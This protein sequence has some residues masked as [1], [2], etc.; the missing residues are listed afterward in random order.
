MQHPPAL[1]FDG[2]RLG[3]PRIPDRESQPTAEDDRELLVVVLVRRDLAA[4]LDPDLVDLRLVARHPATEDLG[5][6]A[7]GRQ[8][9]ESVMVGAFHG[10]PPWVA[11][12]T[13][14][15][16]SHSRPGSSTPSL[17]RVELQAE[18]RPV[19]AIVELE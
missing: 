3:V 17:D 5:H 1:D 15:P 8:I 6:G 2:V 7:I 16:S 19:D 4:G 11:P 12:G 10:Q 18:E 9:G 14:L 13:T